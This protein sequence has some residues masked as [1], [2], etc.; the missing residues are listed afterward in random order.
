MTSAVPIGLLFFSN[1]IF[2]AS[3]IEHF[4]CIMLTR[5]FHVIFLCGACHLKLSAQYITFYHET[6]HC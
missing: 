2:Y 3:Y 1:F 6:L 4:S 5:Y